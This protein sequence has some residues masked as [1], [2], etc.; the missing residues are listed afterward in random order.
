MLRRPAVYFYYIS[1]TV[2]I[3]Q[4]KIPTG[5]GQKLSK[6]FFHP[7]IMLD[8][9]SVGQYHHQLRW[10]PVSE[11]IQYQSLHQMYRQFH[12]QQSH[13][14]SSNPPIQFGHHHLHH[15]RSSMTVFVLPEWFRLTKCQRFFRGRGT[16]WWNLLPAAMRVSAW[17]PFLRTFYSTLYNNFLFDLL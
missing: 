11:L 10:L 15:T 6:V 5:V 7:Q 1:R 2:F 12:S 8:V 4:S 13:C 9:L 14:I 16:L 3:C 17:Q